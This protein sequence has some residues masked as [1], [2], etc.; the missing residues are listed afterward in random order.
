M[1]RGIA[2]LDGEGEVTG[3]VVVMRSGKN[4]RATIA[5]VKAKLEQLKPSLPKGVEVVDTY[6]R[7]KLI[8][9]SI[10]NL[11]LKL[12]EEFIA[13]VLVCAVFLFHLRSAL[14]AVISLP[15]A[16]GIAFVV[17]RWQGLNANI[18][19][20]A[21]IALACG[22]ALDG[23]VVLLEAVHKHIEGFEHA[24]GRRPTAT[25]RWAL[26]TDA[27]VEVGPALFFSLLV[28]TLSFLP[29]FTLEAQEGGCS[30]AARV[31]E[32]VHDGRRGGALGDARPG[33]DGPARARPHSARER[34]PAQPRADARLPAG[35][36]GRAALPEGD[37]RD[38][39]ARARADRGAAA[40]SRRRVHAP[41]DEATCSTCRRRCRDFR[42]R[43][44]R[45]CCSRPTG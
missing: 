45:S 8:D 23:V 9:R 7:S 44:R 43:R 14:V 34:Q 35:A 29:V 26:V 38:R 13:V 20:L 19:S 12:T 16:V 2:E 36:R 1:R 22:A 18:L 6:D 10:D 15:M 42:H 30:L 4:A 39:R 40:A 3:G 32:D 37:A 33:A 28:I 31:H 5:A 21:G 17:M 25:E 11:K 41:L 27:S 24:H